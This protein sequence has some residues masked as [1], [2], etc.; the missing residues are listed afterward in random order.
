MGCSHGSVEAK[1]AETRDAD[2][3]AEPGQIKR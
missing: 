2:I 1:L 3:V